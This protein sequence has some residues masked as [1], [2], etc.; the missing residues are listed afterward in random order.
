MRLLAGVAGWFD[1][2]EPHP[3]RGPFARWPR[4]T[5]AGLALVV[6]LISVG[7]VG[8]SALGDDDAVTVRAVVDVSSG[9][10]A[11][12][13]GWSA[14]L[15][16]RRSQPL[17]VT[18]VLLVGMLAWASLGFGDGQDLPLV[19][20]LYSVGRYHTDHRRSLTIV[21]IAVAVSVVG[22]LVDANQRVDLAPAV[23][24]T[25]LPWYV[26]RRVRNRGDYLALLRDR[27]ERL[28]AE[29]QRRARQAVV[30]ERARIARELHDVVAHRVSMMTVQAGAARTIARH[31][32]DA[33]IEA[34]GDT[35]RAGR[36]ALGEL[37]HLLG[38][39]RPD[40]VELDDVS[41]HPGLADV[42]A[43]VDE[44][45]RA[46]ATI[47]LAIAD[48]PEPLVAPVDLAAYRIVQESLT[49]VVR[50]AGPE[51]TVDVAIT[52]DAGVLDLVVTNA[53]PPASST[54]PGSGLG[55]L[56]MR[57]RAASLGR[58][59]DAGPVPPDRFRVHARLPIEPDPS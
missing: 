1:P 40:G 53:A 54:L 20:A 4:A 33:A 11:L 17:V 26:G 49:N 19:V 47:D 13:A 22:T 7:A 6:F 51:P 5:D 44:L 43:L 21:A 8:L 28:E 37:R 46:G 32:L 31:D 14:A 48:L 39:L 59:L 25:V 35:E 23:V 45:R 41:P 58:S 50:H 55:I 16:W 56:G 24:L 27:A 52:V 34:I 12:L 3:S 18:I 29:Q 57:E 42:P 38:V 15:W 2:G 9:A 10:I 36:Q 30:D